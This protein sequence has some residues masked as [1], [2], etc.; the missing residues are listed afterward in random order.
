MRSGAEKIEST[1]AELDFG[2]FL[3]IHD[4][5]FRFVTPQGAKGEDYDFEIVYPQGL[6]VP[7]DAKCKFVSTRIDPKSVRNSLVK[8][9]KQ[10]P[11]DRPC[12]IFMKVPQQWIS[13]LPTAKALV[14]VG[15]DFMKTTD[16]VVSV[17]FYVSHLVTQDGFVL[18]RHAFR[19]LTNEGSRFSGGRDWDL[20]RDFVVPASWNGMPPS[21][22]RIFFFPKAR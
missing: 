7:A 13:D 14:D 12:V 8:A 17:K 19:E 9:R 20:F 6:L 18:H 22:Q 3:F 1:C 21:W 16:R 2:R 15:R 4:V 5:G 10:L 11:A